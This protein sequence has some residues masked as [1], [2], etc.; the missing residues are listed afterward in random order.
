MWRRPMT[1]SHGTGLSQN[2][3]ASTTPQQ[4]MTQFE[5]FANPVARAR[6][7]EGLGCA[8]SLTEG[9]RTFLVHDSAEA[10]QRNSVPFAWIRR[11][12]AVWLVAKVARALRH[13]M[14]LV[15]HI[16]TKILLLRGQKV[17]LSTH[18]AELYDVL[19]RALVQ[20]VKRN[21][22]RFPSDFMFQLSDEEFANLK[23][24]I[25]TSSWGGQRRASPSTRFESLCSRPS[26]PAAR[27]DFCSEVCFLNTQLR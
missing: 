20:A 26:E 15:Q 13:P 24:Q 4:T 6:V 1:T 3:R 11:S 27:S 9:F 7:L 8:R 22:E 2:L 17:L 21:S 16:E 12:A 19:P 23:S 10:P 14:A 25:V 5:V 18:L